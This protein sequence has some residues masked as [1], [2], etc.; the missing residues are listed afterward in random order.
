MDGIKS[1]VLFGSNYDSSSCD[2]N[3]NDSMISEALSLNT[4][5]NNNNNNRT[6]EEP[7]GRFWSNSDSSGSDGDITNTNEDI[8]PDSTPTS[9]PR[10]KH[11]TAVDQRSKNDENDS[12]YHHTP[13]RKTDRNMYSQNPNWAWDRIRDTQ[14][15]VPVPSEVG[16]PYEN[17]A[18]IVDTATTKNDTEQKDYCRFVLM[19]DTHGR[20]RDLG[21][22]P[23]GDVLIHGGDFT[24]S[25]EKSSVQDL[26]SFFG[27]Y[28][29]SN[30][31][32][33]ILCIAGNHEVTFDEPHY[34]EVWSRFHL[35][36]LDDATTRAALTNCVY[37]KDEAH[38]TKC[39]GLKVY[40]SPWQPEFF[41]WGFNLPRGEPCREKW[42]AIPSD[43]DV[44]ITHGPPLGRGDLCSG[45]TRAG[46]VDLLK[47]VQDRV[48]P[49]L[50]VFGH[51][52]EDAG[53]W[54]D[55]TTMFVNA[56]NVNSGQQTGDQPYVVLDVPVR[57]DRTA[58]T[59]PIVRVLPCSQAHPDV[60][61]W[62]RGQAVQDPSVGALIPYF[63]KAMNGGGIDGESM[64]NA[65][66]SD[67]YRRL[68]LESLQALQI[69]RKT[70][71]L[72]RTCC[73]C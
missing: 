65:P 42:E 11:T 25:G 14:R 40:G 9:S 56:S 55:G 68:N 48:R 62:M 22:P 45:G 13:D 61:A 72:Y 39:G 10:N 66:I 18:T 29:S 34:E 30:P 57:R 31:E 53:I 37:L 24:R 73:Y 47:E 8:D 41:D 43:T 69:L 59:R 67:L 16:R 21:P 2:T 23:R 58:E 54:S 44:L 20:H 60:V 3:S 33:E 50:H 19:S 64:L 6:D 1:R 49:R 17:S 5:F 71:N 52:H 38:T 7:S 26:S 12:I 51:I 28:Q 35:K 36:R 4:S 46:C 32:A 70:R 27:A 63:E 15:F